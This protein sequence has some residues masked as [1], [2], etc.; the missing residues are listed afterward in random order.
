MTRVWIPK[1]ERQMLKLLMLKTE[2]L[3]ESSDNPSD[4]W[5]VH[6]C[7]YLALVLNNFYKLNCVKENDIA[8][9][10]VIAFTRDW[11]QTLL[12]ITQQKNSDVWP[13]D[14]HQPTT[15]S[16]CS[17]LVPHK[18]Q[19]RIQGGSHHTCNMAHPSKGTEQQPSK[20][21]SNTTF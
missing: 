15:N 3:I 18:G 16:T 8:I 5:Y 21:K 20:E 19:P 13:G 2:N 14:H 12:S 4:L 10:W 9:L 1:T 11:L 7:Y 6:I 17:L